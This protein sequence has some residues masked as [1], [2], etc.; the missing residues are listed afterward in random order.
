MAASLNNILQTNLSHEYIW[1]PTKRMLRL[2]CV[3][4]PRFHEQ[5]IATH[6]I[7]RRCDF[8]RQ[9]YLLLTT[10]INEGNIIILNTRSYY[11]HIF[12]IVYKRS[13]LNQ[14]TVWGRHNNFRQVFQKTFGVCC[15]KRE[16]NFFGLLLKCVT[17][18]NGDLLKAYWA[19][20]LGWFLSLQHK[21]KRRPI[22][23]RV[24]F[25][26]FCVR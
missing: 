9:F 1:N 6:Y 10:L 23:G 5:I 2:G 7:T 8:R 14:I 13:R 17:N 25:D 22:I 19:T 15:I 4:P 12:F 18:A 26:V 24:V 16:I 21:S 20:S 3:G 11:K